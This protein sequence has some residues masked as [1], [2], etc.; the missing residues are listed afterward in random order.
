MH[1]DADLQALA[2]GTFLQ[3]RLLQNAPCEITKPVLVDLV[4]WA[5]HD[6][7]VNAS[8][9]RPTSRCLSIATS[10]PSPRAGWTTTST[11]TSTT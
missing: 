7:L 11:V 1:D 2:E 9:P 3:Q 8:G 5:P 6:L 4:S 10:F